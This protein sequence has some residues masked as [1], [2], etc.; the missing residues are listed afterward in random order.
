MVVRAVKGNNDSDIIDLLWSRS[1]DALIKLKE[2][3]GSLCRHVAGNILS[4]DED[5]EECINDTY[6]AVWNNVPPEKPQKLSSYICKIA[7]NISLKK[8]RYNT[9]SKRSVDMN[10]PLS[11]VEDFI[12]SDVGVEAALQNKET[13]THINSFLRSLSF[14]DRNIFLRKYVLGDGVAQIS[15]MFSF[16]ESKV[17]VSLHRTRNKLKDY[18]IKRGIE[19]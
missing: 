1:D 4:C 12:L 15:Q 10:I 5:I 11:E 18:L 9:S 2:K 13:I 3:Y 8:F 19:L 7:R 6:L 17:K 16:T 14:N